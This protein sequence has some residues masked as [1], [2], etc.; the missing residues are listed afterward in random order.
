MEGSNQRNVLLVVLEA[1]SPRSSLSAGWVSLEVS[2]LGVQMAAFLLCPT[3][4]SLCPASVVS[5]SSYKDT[6]C[7]G[8]GPYF[9]DSITSFK[10]LSPNITHDGLQLQHRNCG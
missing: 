10:A 7:S 4:F 5:L 3:A 1:V 9:Y 8:S 2:L 6:S